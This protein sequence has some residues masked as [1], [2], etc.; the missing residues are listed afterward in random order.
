MAKNR[1]KKNEKEAQRSPGNLESGRNHVTNIP[2]RSDPP[3]LLS[4]LLWSLSSFH[5]P[6]LPCC[7]IPNYKSRDYVQR[8]VEFGQLR[9]DVSGM[10]GG[11]GHKR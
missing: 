6:T 10:I 11:G 7:P 9:S 1:L 4:W 3:Y 2:V 5:L 8:G